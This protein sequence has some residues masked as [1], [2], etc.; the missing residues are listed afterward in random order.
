MQD[1]TRRQR[2]C[3]QALKSFIQEHGHSPTWR[4]LAKKMGVKQ[5]R[6]V[7]KHLNALEKKGYI[8]REKGARGIYP[9][10]F[11]PVRRVPIVGEIAAGEPI[12]AEENIRG[13]MPMSRDM[14][15]CD[16]VFFLKVQGDSM[17]NAG[18]F[19]GDFVLVKSQP[20]AR[21]GEVV[22][23]LLD[24]E[25]TVKYFYPEE[26]KVVL[27]PA[28]ETHAPILVENDRQFRVLGKVIGVF[29]WFNGIGHR[30]QNV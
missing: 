20:M 25:A 28:S 24:N 4:E 27:K 21:K 8:R 23:A 29:R 15:S 1:L 19:D 16:D 7:Q 10:D 11:S 18:I 12:L 5:N 9:T 17:R 30:L 2:D 6:T 26:D 13:Y 3:L 14:V 22:V